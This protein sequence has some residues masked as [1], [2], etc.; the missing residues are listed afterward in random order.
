[1]TGSQPSSGQPARMRGPDYVLEKVASWVERANADSELIL[2]DGSSW[3]LKP[4][5]KV[6]EAQRDVIA[7]AIRRNADLFVSGNK[8]I[9]RVDQLTGSRALAV[10][11]VSSKEANGRYRV[12]FYG[13]PSIYH[14]RT[15]RPWT[16][17]ALS[18]L[19]RSATSGA[20]LDS[21]DLLVA[22]DPVT[23][24]IVAVKALDSTNPG[25]SR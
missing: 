24:E 3:K 10:Q 13:P 2:R 15:D 14:L 11:E 22:I 17:G 19:Q 16:G 6:Y 1:M 9:G 8:S 20:F 18:L 21:P 23:S 12:V 25:L 4:G 5:T 7:G